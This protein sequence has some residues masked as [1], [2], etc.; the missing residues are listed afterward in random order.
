MEEQFEE[1]YNLIVCSDKKEYME[2]LGAVVKDMMRKL[3][4]NNPSQAKEYLDVL[5][6]VKWKNYL[7]RKEAEEIVS[8]MDPK[9]AWP[10]YPTWLGSMG[11][12]TSE[13]PYYNSY[14]LF[15]VMNMIWSDSGST[16]KKHMPEASMEELQETVYDLAVDKL[17]DADN[18]FNIRKYFSL[19]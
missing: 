15:T 6:S 19:C 16:L 18:K 7:T 4:S 10:S 14:A 8:K 9:P 13:E 12:P 17:K 1:L 2:V 11:I 5:E 3:I